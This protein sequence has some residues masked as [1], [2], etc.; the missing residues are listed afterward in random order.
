MPSQHGSSKI[1]GIVGFYEGLS[2]SGPSLSRETKLITFRSPT[3]RK[4]M[5]RLLRV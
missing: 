1:V 5:T 2:G 4:Q 3:C